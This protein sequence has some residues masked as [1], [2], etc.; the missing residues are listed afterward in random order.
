MRS[1]EIFSSRFLLQGA[2]LS[3]LLLFFFG[4]APILSGGPPPI[5]MQLNPAMPS[6]AGFTLNAQVVVA[7][8]QAGRDLESDAM[9]LLFNGREVRYLAGYRWNMSVPTLVHGKLVESLQAAD[10]LR[11]VADEIAGINADV[12]LLCDIRQFTLVYANERDIPTAVADFTVRLVNQ[13]TGAL[14]G[15][16]NVIAHVPA[17]G[18]GVPSLVDAYEK[19]LSEALFNI[20]AWVGECMRQ[21]GNHPRR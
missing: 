1:V 20:T 5:R 8:P 18:M 4:C 3:A 2:F 10:I 14:M 16:K 21:A 19:A 11:G 17:Q 15:T 6:K 7:R 9:A 13:R 12:R